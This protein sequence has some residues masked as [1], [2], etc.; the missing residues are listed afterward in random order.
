[1]YCKKCGALLPDDAAFCGKCGAATRPCGGTARSCGAP[2]PAD[3]MPPAASV[4]S[5]PP[6][7]KTKG[8]VIAAVVVALAVICHCGPCP[9]GWWRKGGA[10]DRPLGDVCGVR[11]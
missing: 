2:R 8:I 6:A 10:C 3:Q 4:N 9:A 1:M 11:Q 7:G 5:A